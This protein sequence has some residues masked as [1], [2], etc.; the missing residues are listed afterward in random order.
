[1]I[2]FCRPAASNRVAAFRFPRGL[3]LM[4]AGLGGALTS[5]GGISSRLAQPSR[6]PAPMA[7]A[8]PAATPSAP[9]STPARPADAPASKSGPAG[10]A[11]LQASAGILRTSGACALRYARLR[12]PKS[13]SVDAAE[14]LAGQSGPN[15][16]DTE[17]C[18]AVEKN[19]RAP[20]G[21]KVVVENPGAVAAAIPIELGRVQLTSPK[22][23]V[24]A[25]RAFLTS[26]QPDRPWV[27]GMRGTRLLVD[28]PAG[29]TIDLVFLFE[30][31]EPGWRIAAG[32]KALPLEAV[33][34]GPMLRARKELV[35]AKA[36]LID[37]EVGNCPTDVVL[38]RTEGGYSSRGRVYFAGGRPRLW[39]PGARHTWTGANEGVE[40]SIALIDSAAAAPL[41]FKV[42]KRGY[43][44]AGGTGVVLLSDGSLYKL[45]SKPSRAVPAG[46]DAGNDGAA[47]DDWSQ[48]FAGNGPV[49]TS[50]TNE[51]EH[52]LLMRVKA[53]SGDV[54]AQVRLAGGARTIVALPHGTMTTLIRLQRAGRPRH[55][56]G[57]AI[58]VPANVSQL[59]LILKAASFSNLTPIAEGEFER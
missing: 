55:Y 18:D 20:V 43:T 34:Q 37:L 11:G 27:V 56:R 4:L 24:V 12:H 25:A 51:S 50:L 26:I 45:G 38:N 42:T 2:H 33:E 7:A 57:P 29:Q 53:S 13:Y 8:R 58:E 44:Y 48:L 35:I 40:D 41:Q 54:V 46:S 19:L 49:R 3:L 14:T 16:V 23:A 36:D 31:A 59:D 30:R 15:A 47:A 6:A 1:L 17:P 9:V 28:V 32:T 52:D 39:C 5:C 22:G 21:V 10:W